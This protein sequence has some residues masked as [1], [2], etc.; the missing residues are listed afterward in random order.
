MA[1][2]GL[3]TVMH[4]KTCYLCEY[5]EYVYVQAYIFSLSLSLPLSLSL[6]LFAFLHSQ[7]TI[8]EGIFSLVE[9]LKNDKYAGVLSPYDTGLSEIINFLTQQHLQLI[10]V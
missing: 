9:N 3:T 5:W 8:E 4:C 7:E 6:S 2:Y 1:M 10:T